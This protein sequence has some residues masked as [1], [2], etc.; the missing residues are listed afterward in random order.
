M[1]QLRTTVSRSFSLAQK[2]GAAPVAAF[3]PHWVRSFSSSPQ[4]LNKKKAVLKNA[5][6]W[7]PALATESEADV[8]ADR[9]PLPG[10]VEE[11]QRETV[12]IMT[13][14]NGIKQDAQKVSSFVKGS[15][16]TAK[17]TIGIKEAKTEDK[18]K[19]RVKNVDDKV[20]SDRGA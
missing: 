14:A 16:E 13:E 20:E 9:E 11:L 10:N 15:I 1:S 17:K 4:G 7:N 5:P 19:Q 3:L 6:G 8:K 2:N 12:R 18:I